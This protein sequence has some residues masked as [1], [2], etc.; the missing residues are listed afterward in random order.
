M[1]YIMEYYSAFK[2]KEVLTVAT[3]WVKLKDIILSEISPVTEK[4]NTAVTPLMG[5]TYSS[6]SHRYRRQNVGCQGL[7]RGG[8]WGVVVKWLLRFDFTR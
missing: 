8:L 2:R 6:Q 5:D 3:T 4:T 1:I 7:G